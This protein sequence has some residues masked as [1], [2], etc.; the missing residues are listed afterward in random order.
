MAI[1]GAKSRYNRL[2]PGQFHDEFMPLAL[3]P[4]SGAIHQDLL[5]SGNSGEMINMPVPRF[6]FSE[7]ALKPFG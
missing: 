1:R 3:G 4:G 2:C 5:H 7:M 6:S